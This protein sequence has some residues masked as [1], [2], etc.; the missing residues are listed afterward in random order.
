MLIE[1]VNAAKGKDNVGGG[2]R[3]K[4]DH[5]Y[6]YI[7]SLEREGIATTVGERRALALPI[8]HFA[9]EVKRR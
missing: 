4:K 5:G 2:G 9:R 8:K 3:D 7:M 1:Q 6:N